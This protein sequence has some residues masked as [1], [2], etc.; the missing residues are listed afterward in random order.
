[1]KNKKSL[2]QALKD[3]WSEY[4]AAAYIS[5]AILGITVMAILVGQSKENRQEQ[6]NKQVETYEK[7]LPGYLEQKQMVEHYRDSLIHAKNH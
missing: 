3:W 5:S 4:R 2:K 1:M 6:I 7:T